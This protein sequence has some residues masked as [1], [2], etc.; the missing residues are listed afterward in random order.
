L[1]FVFLLKQRCFDLKKWL[2]QPSD[3]VKIRNSNLKSDQIKKSIV[4]TVIIYAWYQLM[5]V[6]LYNNELNRTTIFL[7]LFEAFLDST[8]PGLSYSI[9]EK[10]LDKHF[11][12]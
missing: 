5:F 2:G 11:L 8:S 1:T 4:T 6:M 9:I 12:L 10:F 7:K 3:S